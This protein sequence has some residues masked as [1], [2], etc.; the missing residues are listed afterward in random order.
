MERTVLP[1]PVVAGADAALI[2]KHFMEQ[3]VQYAEARK[4]AGISLERV[5][6][7]QTPMGDFVIAYLETERSFGE[8]TAS[9][10]SSDLEMDRYFI[11]K[12]KEIH[13]VD[14][15]QPPEGPPPETLAVWSDPAATG[16]GGGFAF[17]APTLPG[18]QDALRA[19]VREAYS[20]DGLARTRRAHGVSHEVVTL[21][22]TPMGDFVSVYSESRDPQAANVGLAASQDEFEVWFKAECR[23]LF[24][25][26]VDFNVPIAGVSEIFDSAALLAP[27]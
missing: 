4:R 13:G 7:Q 25:A 19:F 15:T 23:N 8:T 1:F 26:F 10:L 6:L 17:T 20:R 14:L 3:P 9:M 2:A 18:V 12:V 5:Y 21:I 16:R 27:A 22:T 24:P 11:E